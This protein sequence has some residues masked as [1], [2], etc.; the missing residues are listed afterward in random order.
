MSQRATLAGIPK[1]S[2]VEILSKYLCKKTAAKEKWGYTKNTSYLWNAPSP[3]GKPSNAKGKW[4]EHSDGFGWYNTEIRETENAVIYAYF[5]KSKSERPY[6]WVKN[7]CIDNL[8]SVFFKPNNVVEGEW[9][10]PIPGRP[11]G[12]NQT[13]RKKYC[14]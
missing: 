8:A 2:G 1:G 12:A 6:L 11:G 10:A 7:S 5:T 13:V 9:L 14:K 3:L 4:L